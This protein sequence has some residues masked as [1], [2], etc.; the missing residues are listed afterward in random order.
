MEALPSRNQHVMETLDNLNF[1]PIASKAERIRQM[2]SEIH[3]AERLESRI[4]HMPK[5]EHAIL[6]WE[7]K[8]FLDIVLS[9]FFDPGVTGKAAKGLLSAKPAT[10]ESVSNLLLEE[11]SGLDR[12]TAARKIRDWMLAVHSTIKSDLPTRIAVKH[13]SRLIKKGSAKGLMEVEQ[14]TGLRDN[15]NM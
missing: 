5:S 4:R 12:Q 11:V 6:L 13:Y 8:S 7:E 3:E 15:E 1:S 10:I 2:L 9:E 14:N